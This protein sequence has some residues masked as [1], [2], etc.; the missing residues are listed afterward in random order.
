MTTIPASVTI[1]DLASGTLATTALFEASWT[2]NGVATTLGISISQ[3]ISA[4]VTTLPLPL[5]IITVP[6]ATTAIPA[7]VGAVQVNPTTSLSITLPNS[8]TWAAVATTV[9]VYELSVFDI[10]GSASTNNVT[11]NF[12]GGQTASGQS[13]LLISTNYGGWRFQPILSGGWVVV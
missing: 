7:T 2:T 6:P 1:L 12:F 3:I 9:G 4:V 11:V 13:S 10:S 5:G 8:V